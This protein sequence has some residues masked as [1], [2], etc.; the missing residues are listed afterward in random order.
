MRDGNRMVGR[1]MAAAI[2]FGL[3]LLT[4]SVAAGQTAS[5]SVASLTFPSTP[6]QMASAVMPVTLTNTGAAAL[7]ISS[8]A[9]TGQDYKEFAEANTCGASVAA[10]A[11]CTINITFTP[12]LF[13]TRTSTLAITDNAPN[14]PQSVALSGMGMGPGVTLS[15]PTLN[16]GGQLATT[17][18]AAQTVTLTNSGDAPLTF[19]SVSLTG[20]FTQTNTCPTGSATLAAGATCTFSI[21]FAP[22]AGGVAPGLVEIM[23]NAGPVPQAIT[24]TGTGEDFSLSASP[25]SATV[26]PGGGA[27]YTITVMP[28]GGFSAA[29]SFACGPLAPGATCSFSPASVTPSSSAGV[30]SSLTVSTTGSGAAPGGP[31]QPGPPLVR[32]LL[33]MLGLMAAL[34]VVIYG[35]ARRGRPA[36]A[37]AGVVLAA[38]L[39][40]GLGLPGCGG[41]SS[42]SGSSP[43][44]AGSYTILVNGNTP[45]GAGSLTNPA[46]VTLVVQ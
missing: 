23:D 13:G 10:G 36:S 39:L 29:V 11:S 1:L 18:S 33:L 6:L 25:S 42:S 40:F 20:S 21:T 37:I 3:S 8:I 12:L 5:L 22:S 24:L 30:T 19:S 35:R 41:G 15:P 45:A 28:I 31:V 4:A 9:V 2:G 14:S 43:T 7:S 17:T 32:P 26:S 46:T 44:P 38:I 27:S 16:F 34:F